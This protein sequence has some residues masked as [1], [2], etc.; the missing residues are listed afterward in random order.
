MS[1]VTGALC[2][3]P[4]FQRKS[5]LSSEELPSP[6]GRCPKIRSNDPLRKWHETGEAQEL[7]FIF[8]P[9]TK[10]SPCRRQQMESAVGLLGLWCWSSGRGMRGFPTSNPLS[11]PT[12]AWGMT[13]KCWNHKYYVIHSTK[14][15]PLRLSVHEPLVYVPQAYEKGTV[16]YRCKVVLIWFAIFASVQRCTGVPVEILY[17]SNW[18][19]NPLCLIIYN[20]STRFITFF[21]VHTI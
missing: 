6:I 3:S 20:I 9:H 15:G 8:F 12:K 13:S 4:S 11:W 18:I 1:K 17:N 7:L 16:S 14:L 21:K 19:D 5:T 10:R 2:S